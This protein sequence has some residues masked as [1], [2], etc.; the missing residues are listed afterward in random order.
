MIINSKAISTS[1]QFF[2]VFVGLLLFNVIALRK[3]LLYARESCPKNESMLQ[4]YPHTTAITEQQKLVAQLFQ[5]E[6]RAQALGD[7][8][9]KLN[10]RTLR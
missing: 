2:H 6:L 8:E 1:L 10:T 7:R 9:N 4:L 5:V 3:Y